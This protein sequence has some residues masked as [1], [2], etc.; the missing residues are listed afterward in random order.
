MKID[1][2]RISNLKMRI[3][4]FCSELS[5]LFAD[6]KLGLQLLLLKERKY[7]A[8]IEIQGHSKTILYF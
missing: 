8:L 2:K 7:Q 4:P 5:D 3:D 1:K 6:S